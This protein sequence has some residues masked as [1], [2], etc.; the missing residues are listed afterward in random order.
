MGYGV[1][2]DVTVGV[3]VGVAEAVGVW[4]GVG[5]GVYGAAGVQ[6]VETVASFVFPNAPIFILP[7]FG[8]GSLL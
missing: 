7:P 4:V 2:V 3:C 6:S 5:V 8:M 1:Y